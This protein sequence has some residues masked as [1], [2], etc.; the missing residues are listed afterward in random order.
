MS[1]KYQQH[2]YTSIGIYIT[3]THFLVKSLKGFRRRELLWKKQ[4]L[5]AKRNGK[6]FRFLVFGWRGVSW[7]NV[8]FVQKNNIVFYLSIL[9]LAVSKYNF[10]NHIECKCY[11]CKFFKQ[12]LKIVV[13]LVDENYLNLPIYVLALNWNESC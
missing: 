10:I 5:Q 13:I 12:N 8:C 11:F 6:I 1:S 2:F 3:L 4:D 9:Y 7:F